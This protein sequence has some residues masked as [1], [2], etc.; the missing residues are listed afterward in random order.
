M[1]KFNLEKKPD[2]DETRDVLYW[3]AIRNKLDRSFII[4]TSKGT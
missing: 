2:G 4:Q 3:L 1:D